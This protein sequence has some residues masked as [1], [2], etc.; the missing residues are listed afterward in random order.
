MSRGARCCWP[1]KCRETARR[2]LWVSSFFSLLLFSGALLWIQRRKREMLFSLLH[3]WK[4]RKKR[5]KDGNSSS[6]LLPPHSR[7]PKIMGLVFYPPPPPLLLSPCLRSPSTR[8]LKFRQDFS[9]TTFFFSWN[10]SLAL[11]KDP[12]IEK[13]PTRSRLVPPRKRF[14]KMDIHFAFP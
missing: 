5:K 1:Q 13:W 11:R 9:L 14:S 4:R 2:N 8:S 12:T 7:Q 6:V 3:P 10:A